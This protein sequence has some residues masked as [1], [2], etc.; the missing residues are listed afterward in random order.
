M[1]LSIFT[2]LKKNTENKLYIL[3]IA[4]ANETSLRD[5]ASGRPLAKDWTFDLE[6]T[7]PIPEVASEFHPLQS[8]TERQGLDETTLLLFL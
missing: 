2:I 8:Q 7:G 6:S 1:F 5:Q 4:C 3:K